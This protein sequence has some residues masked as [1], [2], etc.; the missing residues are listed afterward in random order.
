MF[1]GVRVWRFRRRDL[2][3][4]TYL[5]GQMFSSVLPMYDPMLS[6][7][8]RIFAAELICINWSSWSAPIIKIFIVVCIFWILSGKIFFCADSSELLSRKTVFGLSCFLYVSSFTARLLIFTCHQE[9]ESIEKSMKNY[10]SEE[11]FRWWLGSHFC[12][13]LVVGES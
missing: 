13:F 3:V 11:N 9:R 12:P 10:G 8:T 2:F 7:K 6:P 5:P 4:R 1:V